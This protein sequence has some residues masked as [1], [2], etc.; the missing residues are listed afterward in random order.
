M[1]TNPNQA[2]HRDARTKWMIFPTAWLNSKVQKYLILC[3]YTNT[4]HNRRVCVC[5]AGGVLDRIS[6]SN[7]LA[8]FHKLLVNVQQ[9]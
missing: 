4:F 5:V 2:D 1:R 7:P 3:F 6:H 9:K 8:T